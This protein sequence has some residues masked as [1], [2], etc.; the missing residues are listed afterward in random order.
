MV[1]M[2]KD[3]G[4]IDG[5]MFHKYKLKL[6]KTKVKK[7]KFNPLVLL[8]LYKML[9]EEVEL[10]KKILEDHN[11]Y[12]DL[13]DMVHGDGHTEIGLIKSDQLYLMLGKLI[14]LLF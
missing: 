13:M 11:F 2:D 3:G 6:K 1:D 4:E 10:L 7:V 5:L 14:L 8:Q 9:L 12:T